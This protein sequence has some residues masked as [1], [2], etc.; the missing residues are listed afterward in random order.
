MYLGSVSACLAG[1]WSLWED[2]ARCNNTYQEELDDLAASAYYVAHDQL[3]ENH[4]RYTT[5]A[6]CG[7]Y[8]LESDIA[9]NM[10]M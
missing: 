3:A 2:G 4:C 7:I 8:L 9:F 10:Q 5:T 1:S 6:E